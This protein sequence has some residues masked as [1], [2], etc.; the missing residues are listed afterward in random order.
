M[1]PRFASARTSRPAACAYSQVSSKARRP[2][3]PSASK[4]A[5]WGFTA[6]ECGATPSMIPQQKRATASAAALRATW[7]SPRSST[8]RRSSRGSRPTT[9]WERLRSTASARRSA[10]DLIAAGVSTCIARSLARVSEERRPPI[11]RPSKNASS[12]LGLQHPAAAV[13]AADGLLE[14]ASCRELGHPGCRNL[15]LLARVPWVDP[16][17]RRAV[18]RGEL[19]EPRERDLFAV[20]QGIRDRVDHGVDS[21]ARFTTAHIGLGRHPLDELLLGHLLSSPAVFT[22][23][24]PRQTLAGSAFWLNHPV[25]PGT[26]RRRGARKRETAT[27]A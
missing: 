18:L 27:A 7:A 8:G 2:S 12:R 4:N 21:L 9:S 26:F 11:G 14:R 17:A 13:A 22:G 16:L 5:S 10:K 24:G 25:F 3:A 19:A 20:L 23:L 1:S 15:N 6:T